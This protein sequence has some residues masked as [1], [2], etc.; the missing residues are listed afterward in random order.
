[1]NRDVL[2]A[3]ILAAF[4]AGLVDAIAGGGGIITL[5]ALLACGLDPRVALA[6]N[7]G[8][9]VFG[10]GSSVVAFARS[11][12]VDRSRIWITFVVAGLASMAGA[13]LVLLLDPKLL[14]PAVLVLLI[15]ASCAAFVRKPGKQTGW[16]FALKRPWIVGGVVAGVIGS[17]DGFFG[18]GTGTFLILAYAYLFGD[19]LVRASGNAKVANFA[20]NL[21]AFLLFAVAGS[22]RWDLALP[23][24]AAQVAGALIGTRLTVKRGG[25]LVRVAAVTVS[26]L[27]AARVGWQLVSGR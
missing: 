10:S 24:G 9:A 18:P 12:E 3:L 26:L 6:T 20:S 19:P 27:L 5:P 22:I 15:G 2:F 1:M 13:R 23:M 4:A 7:K 17:Y 14:R 16:K 8:Q 21:G 11:G 25:N